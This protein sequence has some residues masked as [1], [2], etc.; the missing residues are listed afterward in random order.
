MR[1]FMD[2]PLYQR[3]GIWHRDGPFPGPYRTIPPF[4]IGYDSLKGGADSA[5]DFDSVD[6][7][8]LVWGSWGKGRSDFWH[9]RAG[10][11]HRAGL[12][13]VSRPTPRPDEGRGAL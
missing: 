2:Y 6:L 11:T 12:P 4:F 10:S 13:S 1:A 5:G 8:L 7:G 9:S 3:G